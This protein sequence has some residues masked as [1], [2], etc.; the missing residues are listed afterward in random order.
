MKRLFLILGVLALVASAAAADVPDASTSSTTLDGT[1]R[2]LLC[3]NGDTTDMSYCPAAN[4]TVV[5][6]NAAGNTIA[7]AVVEILVGCQADNRTRLC[8]I[9]ETVKNTNAAGQVSFNIG[10]GGCCKG[11]AGAAV[12]RANGVTL[13]SFDKVMSPDYAGFDNVGVAGR[14][15]LDVDPVDLG[16]FVAAYQ[17]GIGP[18][19][20]HDYDNSGVTDPVDLGTF[21]QAYKG[22]VGFCSPGPNAP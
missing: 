14:A 13:R 18:A 20:C 9:N 11:E 7:N 12:I 1:G 19:S 8:D 16:A 10:G 4:F 5:V 3:P 6:R 22:G 17:G 15:D 21:V 2:L